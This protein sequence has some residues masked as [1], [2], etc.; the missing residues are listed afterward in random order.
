M[1]R[2]GEKL[3]ILFRSVMF[4]SIP[5]EESW[6]TRFS[7]CSWNYVFMLIDVTKAWPE[8]YVFGNGRNYRYWK[9]YTR[10]I[11]NASDGFVGIYG[12]RADCCA[13]NRWHNICYQRVVFQLIDCFCQSKDSWDTC[14]SRSLNCAFGLTNRCMFL[15]QGRERTN[16]NDCLKTLHARG[17]V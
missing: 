7:S 13:V 8:A 4:P 14:C 6:R 9:D 2:S 11:G 5:F 17:C 1:F 16:R 12:S 15:L 10:M 3:N